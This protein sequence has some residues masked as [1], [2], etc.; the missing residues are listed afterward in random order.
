MVCKPSLQKRII[1]HYVQGLGK[2]AIP[3]EKNSI[4]P[5]L[6]KLALTT[7]QN[8]KS[9]H[10]AVEQFLL[11]NDAAT[12]CSEL[13]IF[14]NPKEIESLDIHTPLTGHIDLI[15][16]KYDTLFILDYKPNLLHPEQYTDNC[17][18]Y[19]CH[20]LDHGLISLSSVAIINRQYSIANG[21]FD[22]R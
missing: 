2:M 16:I 17:Q 14:I 10:E 11:I 19:G 22:Y 3:K 18:D 9:A 12:V 8:S 1:P 7:S 15:Q 6:T 21:A 4:I 13:P 5:K 20:G